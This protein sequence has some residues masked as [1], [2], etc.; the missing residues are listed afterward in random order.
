MRIILWQKICA[1]RSITSII[2]RDIKWGW[3]VTCRPVVKGAVLGI[4]KDIGFGAI[5]RRC[6]VCWACFERHD[7][8]CLVAQIQPCT[9]DDDDDWMS[10]CPEVSRCMEQRQRKERR[11]FL[12]AGCLH[13]QPSGKLKGPGLVGVDAERAVGGHLMVLS[14][15][16]RLSPHWEGFAWRGRRPREPTAAPNLTINLDEHR[17][18]STNRRRCAERSKS[19]FVTGHWRILCQTQKLH[20]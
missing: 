5:T 13:M 3:Q 15:E 18:V 6:L 14:H 8:A 10:S 1:R 11:D 7:R 12:L 19:V 4:Q 9:F 16:A 20:G 2:Q 17:L